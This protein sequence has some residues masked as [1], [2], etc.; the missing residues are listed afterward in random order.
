MD[1]I[2]VGDKVKTKAGDRMNIEAKKEILTVL[3]L[4]TGW[5]QRPSAKCC[6]DNKKVRSFL[7]DNL[8]KA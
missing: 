4:T 8:Y 6:G 1:K 7:L 2:K 3:E 5:A